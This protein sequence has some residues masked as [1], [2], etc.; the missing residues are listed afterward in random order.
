VPLVLSLLD[1]VYSLR[2]Q[3]HALTGAIRQQA[4]DVRQATLDLL[5]A[6]RRPGDL[7]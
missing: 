1:Q 4:E 6:P 3:M 7:A 5:E 2:R